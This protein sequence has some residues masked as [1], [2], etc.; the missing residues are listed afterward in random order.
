MESSSKEETEGE[1][2]MKWRDLTLVDIHEDYLLAVSCDSAGGIGDKTHD[3]VRT[4]PFIVGYHTAKVALMELLCV[5]GEPI[6]LS[7][8]LSV[9]MHPAGAEMM[10]GIESLLKEYDPLHSIELTGSTEENFRVT[11]TGLGVTIVGRI[12]KSHWPLKKTEAEDVAVMVG[13]AKYGEEVL[14]TEKERSLTL[15]HVKILREL[16]YV[17]EVVPG[18]SRGMAHEIALVERA[19]QIRFLQREAVEPL[20]Y[21]SCGPA[22]ALLVTLRKEHLKDLQKTLNVPVHVLGVFD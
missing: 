6:L 17:R 3:V 16:S 11:V 4:S 12:K 18:G 7:S 22:S 8:T 2:L 1:K 14:Q 13:D 19:S 10:R 21:R 20:L 5:Y 15:H 9:E